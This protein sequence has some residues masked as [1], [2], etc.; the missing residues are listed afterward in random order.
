MSWQLFFIWIVSFAPLMLF[1]GAPFCIITC[2]R[3]RY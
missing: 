1:Y 3:M 2:L